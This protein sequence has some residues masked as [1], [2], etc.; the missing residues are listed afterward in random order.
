MRFFDAVLV[1]R[2]LQ[3]GVPLLTG[4]RKLVNAAG[5]TA[6]VEILRGVL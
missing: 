1:D 2:A 4:N 6:P 5:D 3:R